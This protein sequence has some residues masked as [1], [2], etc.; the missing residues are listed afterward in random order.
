MTEL[1]CVSIPF[2]IAMVA[3]IVIIKAAP[4]LSTWLPKG[5]GFG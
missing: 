5:F 2:L 4:A 3:C 1:F